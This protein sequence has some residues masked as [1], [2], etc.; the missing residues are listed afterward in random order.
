MFLFLAISI[1]VLEEAES[2]QSAIIERLR[3]L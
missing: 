2:K 1:F 3:G